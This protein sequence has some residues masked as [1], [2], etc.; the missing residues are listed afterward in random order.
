MHPTTP[1]S[2]E[3]SKLCCTIVNNALVDVSKSSYSPSWYVRR[4]AQR[5]SLL[6]FLLANSSLPECD[7]SFLFMFHQTAEMVLREKINK[8]DYFYCDYEALK[9]V[10]IYRCHPVHSLFPFRT[11]ADFYL[12]VTFSAEKSA[13]FRPKKPTFRLDKSVFKIQKGIFSVSSL[14]SA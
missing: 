10:R 3:F 14:S 7:C 6:L 12:K 5:L 4:K 11:G 2:H 1:V 8:K 13:F 9:V